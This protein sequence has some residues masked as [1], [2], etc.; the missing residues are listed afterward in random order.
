MTVLTK[1]DIPLPYDSEIPWLGIY[2]RQMKPYAAT[3]T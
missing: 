2:W 1:L 3:Q